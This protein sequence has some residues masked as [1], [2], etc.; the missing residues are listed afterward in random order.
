MK[1]VGKTDVTI[2][3]LVY[4]C[5]Q[6]GGDYWGATDDAKAR[7]LVRYA[8]DRGITT[9]DT[10]YC[11][12]QGRAE[13]TLGD[14]LTGVDR[15]SYQ[16]ISKLWMDSL[17]YE[18]TLKA[19]E[20]SLRRLKVDYLDVYFIH[21][22]DRTGTMPISGTMRA[23]E[24]LRADGKI[25]AIGVSNFSLKQIREA[26][27]YGQIDINQPCYNLLWRYIDKK[28]RLY[29]MEHSI[30]II[31][32][33]SLAQGLLTGTYTRENRPVSDGRRLSA[34]AQEPYYTRAMTVT[35][36][37]VRIAKKYGVSGASVA[38]N[39]N[40]N[41]PGITAPIVGI[42]QQRDVDDL[43][44]A[45]DLNLAPEDRTELDRVSRA[46]CDTM[47]YFLSLFQ[48]TIIPDPDEDA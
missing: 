37:V 40:M 16:M 21:Y 6:M 3:D 38:L 39:W 48:P 36:E 2:S 44:A 13:S 5:W 34:L 14:I 11:Y 23:L 25:R 30:S 42:S 9:F 22:P 17:K 46:F 41:Q 4:G 20:A 26:S 32:Y 31:P 7:T 24:K 10:A 12:G 28:V 47:P 33:S 27:E 29:C 1:Q 35:D 43:F 8:I 45:R 18:D 15:S 19:C